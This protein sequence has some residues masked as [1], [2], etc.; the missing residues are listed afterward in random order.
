MAHT[1]PILE[2][3]DQRVS[4]ANK[5][6]QAELQ[7]IKADR[8]VRIGN[9]RDSA[10]PVL[11]QAAQVASSNTPTTLPAV[12]VITQP[13]KTAAP[14][15]TSESLINLQAAIGDSTAARVANITKLEEGAKQSSIASGSMIDSIRAITEANQTVSLVKDTADLQAQNATINAFEQAGGME[16]QTALMGQMQ[17]DFDRLEEFQNER[18]AIVDQEHTG[19]QFIDTIIN[20]FSSVQTN[21]QIGAAEDQLATTIK[22]IGTITSATESISRSAALTK[23]TVNASTIQANYERLGAEGDFKAAQQEIVNIGTNATAVARVMSA[24]RQDIA[25]LTSLYRLEGEAEDRVFRKETQTFKREQWVVQKKQWED[26]AKAREVQLELS[27][28]ALSNAKLTDPSGI[29]KAIAQ[30]EAALKAIDDAKAI[31][32]TGGRAVMAG[33]SLAGV[34]VDTLEEAV[35][36]LLGKGVTGNTRAQY[37]TFRN[38]GDAV[39]PVMGDTPADAVANYTIAAPEGNIK[40]NEVLNILTE[41]SKLQAEALALLPKSQ[42]PQTI[43]A[44]QADYNQRAEAY[45]IGKASNIATGDASNPYQGAPFSTLEQIPAIAESKLYTAV[46]AATGMKELNPQLIIDSAVAGILAGNVS[47]NEAA[48]GVAVIFESAANLN[49]TDPE[50]GGFR[51]AGLANQTSFN[52]AL[53][54]ET[55]AFEQLSSDVG[56]LRRAPLALAAPFSDAAKKALVKGAVKSFAN[57]LEQ[58]N[59]MDETAVQLHIVKQLSAQKQ[60][61]A[62]DTAKNN[63]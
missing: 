21:L 3:R 41:V 39:D 27:E 43:E 22:E 52:V 40:G 14:A 54:R 44:L 57:K 2:A 29:P 56:F 12:D 63:Q 33:Q 34:K 49:N 38:L 60:A 51:R 6:E 50:T 35:H 31:A 23:E 5:T 8:D 10:N 4:I 58:V 18:Q 13:T 28:R 7:G 17:E 1:N 62:E 37:E 36:G 20:A 15:P 11:Q 46:L 55:T 26:G 19:I 59:L 61:P 48:E 47:P 32:E 16:A 9:T 53:T 42:Q 24:R 45:M 30:N 25:D